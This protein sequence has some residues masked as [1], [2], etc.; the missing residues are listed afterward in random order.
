[1]EINLDLNSI[2]KEG[3]NIFGII[4]FK[5][6]DFFFPEKNWSDF[7]VII[8]NWWSNAILKLLKNEVLSAE[9]SFMDGP[10]LV[11]INYSDEHYI[12]FYFVNN[13]KIIDTQKVL[14]EEFVNNFIKTINSLIRTLNQKSLHDHEVEILK[15]NHEKLHKTFNL[16]IW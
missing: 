12:T 7:I 1:M 10:F 2:S 15:K 13:D 11:K 3:K 9:L 8:M 4:H 14:F 16:K 6:K 5:N